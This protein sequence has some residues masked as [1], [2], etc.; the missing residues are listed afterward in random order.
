[1][2]KSTQEAIDQGLEP[3]NWGFPKIHILIQHAF[4]NIEAKGITATY[5]TKPNE[6]FHG[7]I[8]AAYEH[9]NYKN[10]EPQVCNLK[11]SGANIIT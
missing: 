2:E 4:D 3:K 8:R 5:S 7:P 6:E 11:I 9:T 10:V 1:M